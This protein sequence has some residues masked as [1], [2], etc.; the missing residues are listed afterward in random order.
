MGL[1]VMV[2]AIQGHY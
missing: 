2:I 1:M